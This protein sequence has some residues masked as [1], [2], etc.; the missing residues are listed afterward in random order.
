MNRYFD[1]CLSM[2]MQE[3]ICEGVFQYSSSLS[4]SGWVI[5]GISAHRAHLAQSYF[6]LIFRAF[7]TYN[8]S[9][10]NLTNKKI[11]SD[12][13]RKHGKKWPMLMTFFLTA[14]VAITGMLYVADL[15]LSLSVMIMPP[16]QLW[17]LKEFCFP[18]LSQ[19]PQSKSSGIADWWSVTTHCP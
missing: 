2:Q 11:C 15:G 14:I 13:K 8:C 17:A 16:W 7:N 10:F 6:S 12:W 1:T 18:F 5:L 3:S 19:P 9:W 4:S